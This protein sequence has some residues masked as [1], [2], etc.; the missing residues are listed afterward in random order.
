MGNPEVI[1]TKAVQLPDKGP[2]RFLHKMAGRRITVAERYKKLLVSANEK[3]VPVFGANKILETNVKTFAEYLTKHKN[4]G[5]DFTYVR[6]GEEIAEAKQAEERLVLI[7]KLRQL[8]NLNLKLM[9]ESG[10]D[11]ETRMWCKAVGIPTSDG[12]GPK[13]TT[14]AM[15]TALIDNLITEP[16]EKLQPQDAKK[17]AGSLV[18]GAP[19]DKPT[20]SEELAEQVKAV[21]ESLKAD[22]D[23]KLEAKD[24]EFKKLLAEANKP[25]GGQK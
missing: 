7:K 20:I 19:S 1:E 3:R 24:A 5:K 21:S 17:V 11:A 2:Y 22:F 15:Q 6:S 23:K 16:V 25:K 14:K 13:L 10:N 4:Y 8:P 9:I 12:K 18:K